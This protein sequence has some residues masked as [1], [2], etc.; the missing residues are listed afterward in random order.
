LGLITAGIAE[1]A[2]YLLPIVGL[3]DAFVWNANVNCATDPPATPVFDQSDLEILALGLLAPTA[4]QTL[5]KIQDA[6]TIYLWWQDCICD[7]PNTMAPRPVIT[8]TDQSGG[9]Y[10]PT[11]QACVQAGWA[12]NP[13]VA[14]GQPLADFYQVT[15]QFLPVTSDQGLT[16]EVGV[17]QVVAYPINPIYSVSFNGHTPHFSGSG[18]SQF[19]GLL[20]RLYDGNGTRIRQFDMRP[21]TSSATVFD[22]DWTIDA[23][24]AAVYGWAGIGFNTPGSGEGTPLEPLVA[25]VRVQCGTG[26]PIATDCCPPDPS[27]LFA[28]N[29]VLQLE[30][31]ILNA[32]AQQHSYSKGA[33]HVGLVG[34]GSLV[35][36][37]IVGVL[38]DIT[39]QPPTRVQPGNPA[40]IWDMG[41]LSTLT[42][43]G[44]I[45]EKRLTRSH[46]IWMPATATAATTIGYYLNPGV[47]ATI[48][49][50]N[51]A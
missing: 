40:Y 45:E 20:Y 38:V 28:L 6:V 49:L 4:G 10:L 9:S 19:G 8:R 21:P 31:R 33:A 5:Q 14:I 32:L 44:M 17:D 13:P 25:N 24:P 51:P 22:V 15:Q 23:L 2:P 7:A 27:V 16:V 11:A 26:P 18:Y 37:D 46:Q 39:A 35:V 48:T 30:Q 41:W 36:S 1:V 42:G 12:G 43:D 50:L 29:Q 34:S 3:V 47:T